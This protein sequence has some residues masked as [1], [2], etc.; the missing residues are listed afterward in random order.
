MRSG[1]EVALAAGIVDRFMAAGL[2]VYGPTQAAA[3]IETSKVFA[4]RFMPR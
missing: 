1:P 3:Q 2:K 4:K